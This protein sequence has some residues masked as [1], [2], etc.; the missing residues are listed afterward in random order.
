[1]G[2]AYY[3]ELEG[4]VDGVDLN[5]DGKALGKHLDRLDQVA[6]E[7]GVRP[8]SEFATA[9]PSLVFDDDELAELD[10]EPSEFHS[11]EEGL[12]TV[13][14]LLS[15]DAFTDKRLLED[16]RSLEKILRQAQ[17]AGVRWQLAMDI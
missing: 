13:Q 12:E 7:M 14:S 16:L 1:M 6:R 11:V 17:A 10:L 3:V 8:L 15:H 9:D 4:D 2:L 5:M